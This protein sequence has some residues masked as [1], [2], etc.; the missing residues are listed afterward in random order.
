[1]K[2]VIVGGAGAMGRKLVETVVTFE[3][4]SEVAVL[5]RDVERLGALAEELGPKVKPVGFDALAD[6][7]AAYLRD[8]RVVVSTLG[9]FTVFG[10]RVLSAAIEAGCDYLD[11]NDDWEPTLGVLNLDG[12]A[13]DAGIT[14]L[15]G[16]GLSP[17]ISNL[18]AVRA[19]SE[20]DRVD[21]LYTGWD[22]AGARTEPGGPRPA[23]ATVHLVNECTG[24]VQVLKDGS[25]ELVRPLERL[26]LMYPGR[27][28]VEVRTIG[29]PEAVTLP[30]VFPNLR[31][32][33]NV[34]VAP[35]WW[36][37][38]LE[39]A[40]AR[41]DTGEL[42]AHEA[43]VLVEDG[44]PRPADAPRSVRMPLVWALAH[45]E[46]D[47]KPTRVSAGLERWPDGLMAGGTCVPAAMAVRLMLQGKIARPGVV[48]PEEVVPFAPLMEALDPLYVHP[49][50]D[51]PLFDVV[52]DEISD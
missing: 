40:M 51:R 39:A 20:L 48:T 13:R 30:R 5:D 6:D 19:A 7:Y 27:G 36:F 52:A 16:M 22:L 28:E 18:L 26:A 8:A 29:H 35:G 33:V 24:K 45:G 1:M 4:V 31:T 34:M 46:R 41:V 15:V 21:E 23:A 2:V 9:P 32:C 17:G 42:T 47:G 50:M 12:R 49:A 11:I 38:G 3:E 43:A 37:D 44:F 14:A 25:A 10:G